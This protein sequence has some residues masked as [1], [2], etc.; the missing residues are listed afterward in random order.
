MDYY[1]EANFQK[2]FPKLKQSQYLFQSQN[3]LLLDKEYQKSQQ[4]NYNLIQSNI[5]NKQEKVKNNNFSDKNKFKTQG[6]KKINRNEVDL[7]LQQPQSSGR[8]SIR[9]K[10]E[11]FNKRQNQLD[12]LIPLSS[13]ESRFTSKSPRES[14][15]F[16]KL[17]TENVS[18]CELNEKQTKVVFEDNKVSEQ[19]ESKINQQEYINLNDYNVNQLQINL[20]EKIKSVQIPKKQFD[21][22]E[23]K[24]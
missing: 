7:D 15:I 16:S 18:R 2:Q 4:Q 11:I 24:D 9:F 20:K 5:E 14:N 21:D 13:F 12:N 6:T 17:Q 10:L 1:K 19:L 3:S 23:I 8:S 22:F